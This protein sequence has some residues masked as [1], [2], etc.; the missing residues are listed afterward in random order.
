MTSS[1]FSLFLKLIA[2]NLK[3]GDKEA[4]IQLLEKSADAIAEEQEEE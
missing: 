3:S 2:A 1:E 4:V